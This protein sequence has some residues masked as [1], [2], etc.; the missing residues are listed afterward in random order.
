MCVFEM[1]LTLYF[2]FLRLHMVINI[3]LSYIFSCSLLISRSTI[4]PSAVLLDSYFALVL[5]GLQ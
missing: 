4:Y 5:V 3:R 2:V 1:M